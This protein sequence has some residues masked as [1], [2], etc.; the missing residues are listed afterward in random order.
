MTLGFQNADV[1][2]ETT[3]A[4]K[5]VHAG[6]KLALKLRV[7]ACDSLREVAPEER[8]TAPLSSR[9]TQGEFV[10]PGVAVC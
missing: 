4:C 2:D 5:L 7:A 10:T 9:Q 3:S 8:P 1:G 6:P